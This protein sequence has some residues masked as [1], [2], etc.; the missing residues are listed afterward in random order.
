[1]HSHSTTHEAALIGL[2]AMGVALARAA[3]TKGR[4]IIVWNRTSAKAAP[5]EAAGVTVAGSVAAAVAASPVVIVCVTDYPATRSLLE[6]VE[7]AGKT[8]VQLSTGTPQEARELAGWATARGARYLDGA[9]L[10]VPSQIGGPHANIMTSG[11]PEAFAAAQA[12]LADMG[13][14]RFAGEPP[15]AA[16]A[17]DFGVLASLFGALLGFYHG[18][19]LMESEGLPVDSLGE[20][21][22][23]TAPA[24][25]EMIRIDAEA[26]H[27]GRYEAPEASLEIC[28]R[29]MDLL[30]RH[31]REAA[32]DASFPGFAAAM[33][34][35]GMAAGL[36][37]EAPAAMIKVLRAASAAEGAER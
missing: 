34:Q 4:R 6:S 33:F 35:R 13:A 28:W 9:I 24:M 18:A 15:G 22:A 23:A 21:M 26:I 36:G 8:L 7:L 32:I 11:A 17:L 20:V 2:G 14:V 25:G 27:H 30:G 12:L 16:A 1:M 3:A 31:A 29:S 10:A 5:L 19:R 37:Q